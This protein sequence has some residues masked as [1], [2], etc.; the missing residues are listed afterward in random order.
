[1]DRR[2]SCVPKSP[3]H[4]NSLNGLSEGKNDAGTLNVNGLERGLRAFCEMKMCCLRIVGL[5][6]PIG[7][8]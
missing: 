1:M 3:T 7:L 6:L 4:L 8:G 2:T 5:A